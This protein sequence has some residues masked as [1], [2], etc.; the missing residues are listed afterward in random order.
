MAS[1]KK[2]L[3][4]VLCL[5]IAFILMFSVFY[6]IAEMG[7]ECDGDHCEICECIDVCTDLLKA[8]LLVF[9]VFFLA[10]VRKAFASMPGF[11]EKEKY[12]SMT[13][14]GLKVRLNN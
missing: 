1:R 11:F 6:S 9:G 14:V 12:P 10:F 8:S 13:Q 4:T 7:H 3:S 2:I 5:L